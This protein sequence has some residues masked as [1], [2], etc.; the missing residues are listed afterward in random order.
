MWSIRTTSTWAVSYTHLDVYKRQS[1]SRSSHYPTDIALMVEAPIFH[2][3]GA[4]P[5]AVVHAAKV[6]T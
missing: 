6:A 2:V 4:D 5:E 1:Y 3:N